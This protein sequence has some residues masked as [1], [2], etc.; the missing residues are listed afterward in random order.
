MT[1]RNGSKWK[2]FGVVRGNPCI[3]KTPWS[4]KGD[5]GSENM[6]GTPPQQLKPPRPREFKGGGGT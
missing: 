3:T 2:D 5:L 4:E 6:G 1:G